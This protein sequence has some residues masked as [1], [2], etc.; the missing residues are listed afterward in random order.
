MMRKTLH[1]V[2]ALALAGLALAS[3]LGDQFE[4]DDVQLMTP[5]NGE[6]MNLAAGAS[7]LKTGASKVVINVYAPAD[8]APTKAANGEYDPIECY[9]E[10]VSVDEASGEMT[11]L[12]PVSSLKATKSLIDKAA[13]SDLA[14]NFVRLDENIVNNAVSN[15]YPSWSQGQ[16]IEA[17]L[18]GNADRTDDLYYRS[19]QFA[20]SQVYKYLITGDAETPDTTFY[21]TRLVGWYPQN[22]TLN[23]DDDGKAIPVN[24]GSSA[25][26]GQIY[27]DN[28]K[29]GVIFSGLDGSKDIMMSTLGEGQHW[30]T[31]AG[32]ENGGHPEDDPYRFPFGHNDALPKYSN[33]LFYHHFLT[34]VRL[35]AK[36]E[37]ETTLNLLTW[38]NIKGISFM[39]QPTSCKV[40]FPEN[41][42]TLEV[43]PRTRVINK[44]S[45]KLLSDKIDGKNKYYGNVVSWDDVDNFP[46][47]EEYMYGGNDISHPEDLEAS[48]PI[49]IR[50]HSTEATKVYL[51]YGLVKPN[52]DINISI[53]TAAGSYYATLST[54]FYNSNGELVNLF[55]PSKVYDVTLNLKTAG[56]LDDFIE[57][58]DEQEYINL[59]TWDVAQNRFRTANSYI[60]NV[61]EIQGT[62]NN[63]K[64][65]GYTFI[66]NMIGNGE[67]GILDGFHTN[68]AEISKEMFPRL[69][70]ESTKGLIYNLQIQH[71]YIRFQLREAREGNAVVAVVD[72][73][74][75][76]M[77]SWHVWITDVPQDVNM[78]N[79]IIFMDRNLGA[80]DATS[81]LESYGLYYQ[82]GRKD[83]SPG[84]PNATYST[85]DQ[86]I[87]PVFNHKGSKVS[88]V[89]NYVAE[90]SLLD[91]VQNPHL[92][93][94]TSYGQYY[95]Y[96]WV[97]GPYDNLWG[98]GTQKT[99]YDPC[100][101]GYMV[102]KDQLYYVLTNG[103][104]QSQNGGLNVTLNENILRLP[105]AGYKGV[106]R[107][108]SSLA[109]PWKYVGTKGDYLDSSLSKE[110]EGY[111]VRHRRR[112]YITD[113][114][115]WNEYSVD[116]QNEYR[117]TATNNLLV[118]Y[119]NR[120]TAGS[121]RCVKDNSIQDAPNCTITLNQSTMT[122][123]KGQQYTVSVAS[124]FPSNA[125]ITWSVEPAGIITITNSGATTATFTAIESGTAV[126][127][128]TASAPRYNPATA[129][130]TVKVRKDYNNLQFIYDPYSV[131]MDV[132]QN[133]QAT[134]HATAQ[135]N[136]QTINQ[137]I[138]W[139]SADPSIASVT[140]EGVITAHRVGTVKV[141]AYMIE[142]GIEYSAP[143]DNGITVNVSKF[144]GATINLNVQTRELAPGEYFEI[145]ATT[146]PDDAEIQWT[147]NNDYGCPVVLSSTTAKTIRVTADAANAIVGGSGRLVATI[148]GPD[149]KIAVHG[150]MAAT[151]N[152]RIVQK[153][154]RITLNQS[155][156]DLKVGETGTIGIASQTP[157]QNATITWSSSD[158]SIASVDANG[159]VT[160]VAKGTATITATLTANG[161]TQ[162][163]ATCTVN[164]KRPYWKKAT[165][166]EELRGK[167]VVF[168][169]NDNMLQNDALRM[170]G[171][172]FDPDVKDYNGNTYIVSNSNDNY[173]FTSSANNYY[174]YVNGS[175]NL[176]MANTTTLESSRQ[177]TLAINNGAFTLTNVRQ[178]NRRIYVNNNNVTV[179]TNNSTG[180]EIWYRDTSV[181]FY[182]TIEQ[183]GFNGKYVYV[184][185][186]NILKLSAQ[187]TPVSDDHKWEVEFNAQ[188]GILLKHAST[189][190]YISTDPGNANSQTIGTSTNRNDA[191]PIILN[192][193]SVTPQLIQ[194]GSRYFN[195][196]NGR[197]AG[198][199]DLGLYT[200]EDVQTFI[201]RITN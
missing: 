132:Y 1:N 174:L 113:A 13:N 12:T 59:S 136:G 141:Y 15:T 121:V 143:N 167:M 169:H 135:Q 170:S 80:T 56:T 96:D 155:S 92:L 20:P 182:I 122:V 22:I 164:V 60:V 41:V 189:G 158:E 66:A 196:W 146:F 87:N 52:E 105:Y 10:V 62:I 192:I 70:W 11:S 145:T 18:A 67:D 115:S 83:P 106:E 32:S 94:F 81:G 25:T 119:T 65:P 107:G 186:D 30:H 165:S 199:L 6:Q 42:F 157:A 51:G 184:N 180:F 93:L 89:K 77:W 34:A 138:G 197:T 190:R 130:C 50:D 133:K 112:N 104:K 53:Q 160:A 118:D 7:N 97:N 55:D 5:F 68:T 2:I 76:I 191:K 29:Y 84:A 39:N 24:V 8:A 100:P 144:Q 71:G 9:A 139:M 201:V 151:C 166:V 140:N 161:Y 38:G 103:R 90:T 162:A 19:V 168:V 185:N 108:Q 194:I 177:W 172:T 45:L 88:S 134:V 58:E 31:P 102:P 131:Q 79:D 163:S 49:S 40:E 75:N 46:I 85:A 183:N 137:P 124:V 36:A 123:T 74:N 37:D 159:V 129:T 72:S 14:S 91:G 47:R 156:M 142:D 43:N 117:F 48:Y 178:N 150:G 35:F 195:N 54:Q 200:R 154:G 63:G 4:K 28:G 98:D 128:A 149:D 187:N 120:K 111:N 179:S 152:I 181:D 126:I 147:W 78:G 69:V 64:I 33:P 27:S 114:A 188:G 21:H 86:S 125:T 73:E 23:R 193:Y 26:A 127:K 82:W 44:E 101:Y 3:C 148:V 109:G 153:E 99:I 175:N 16:V 173:T 17:T 95:T 110:T 61:N 198:N 57:N 171:G 116:G 176:A